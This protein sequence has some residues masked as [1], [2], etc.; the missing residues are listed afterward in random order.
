MDN[1][2][3]WIS[4]EKKL[5]QFEQHGTHVFQCFFTKGFVILEMLKTFLVSI[6]QKQKSPLGSTLYNPNKITT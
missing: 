3:F 5:I 6:F 2:L 1:Y 4:G